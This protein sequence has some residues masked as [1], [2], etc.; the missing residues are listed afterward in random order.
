M[1]KA[2]IFDCFGVLVGR[3]F[4]ETYRFAGGNPQKDHEFIETLLEKAN[5]GQISQVEFR[6]KIC[7]RLNITIEQYRN[8]IQE[9]EQPDYELLRYIKD[10]RKQYKVAVLSNV[11][12]GVL[13]RKI[14]EKWLQ[15]CFDACVVSADVG[16]IK[17]EREIYELTAKR[18]GVRISE[19]VFIDDREKYTIA[20]KTIGMKTILYKNF[21]QMKQELEKLLANP[22]N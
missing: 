6:A 12:T 8:A 13:E 21:A 14:G 17:P 16:Y 11:N 9:A 10:L 2:I 22:N 7:D 15:E 5:R 3:G 19:C 1:I 20:A 4:D 18:L